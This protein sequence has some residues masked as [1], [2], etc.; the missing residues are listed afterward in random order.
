LRE[1]K[2]ARTGNLFSA[3]GAAFISKPG[4]SAPGLWKS[5]RI[6]PRD[7]GAIHF[8]QHFES[9]PANLNR[10]FS[11]WLRGKLEFLGRCPKFA[12]A[13]PSCGGLVWNSAFDAKEKVARS[14]RPTG[15]RRSRPHRSPATAGRRRSSSQL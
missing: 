11:A 2:T 7:C 12:A 9:P 15:V 14:A 10:A 13:N 5:E 6:Q 3:N 8:R 1:L 4:G